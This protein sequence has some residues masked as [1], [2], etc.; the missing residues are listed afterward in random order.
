MKRRNL[1]PT[2]RH[3]LALDELAEASL[4]DTEKLVANAL[5]AIPARD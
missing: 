3:V 1:H 5:L 2:K 4:S